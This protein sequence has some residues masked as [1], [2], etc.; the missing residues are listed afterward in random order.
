M[1]RRQANMSSDSGGAASIV[2][3]PA[4][5][6]LREPNGGHHT[7]HARRRPQARGDGR[8]GDIRVPDGLIKAEPGCTV[9]SCI[10]VAAHS[11]CQPCFWD[12]GTVARSVRCD[13][14][15]R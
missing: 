9:A 8:I 15:A 13:L 1:T 3:L 5:P 4:A 11:G 10:Q 7:G 14:H 2:A 12:G 6:P